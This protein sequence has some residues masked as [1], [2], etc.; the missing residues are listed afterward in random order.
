MP[1][2]THRY[3][4]RVALR[5][6]ADRSLFES[7]AAFAAGVPYAV[8]CVKQQL[9]CASPQADSTHSRPW[10][11]DRALWQQ[12][13]LEGD[14]QMLDAL[15]TL[16]ASAS[17]GDQLQR[18]LSDIVAWSLGHTTDVALLDWIYDSFRGMK[19]QQLIYYEHQL[20]IGVRGS[21]DV[22]QWMQR[23]G[24]AVQYL[25][26]TF[27]ATEHG[28]LELLRFVHASGHLTFPVTTIDLAATHGHLD[29]VQFLHAFPEQLCSSAA[30][31][32]AARN[33]HVAIV[34]FL[35]AHRTE[36]D[37]NSAMRLATEHGHVAC[38]RYLFESASADMSSVRVPREDLV[39]IAAARGH[40]ACLEYFHSR[41]DYFRFTE[42]AMHKAAVANHFAVV[43]FL[44]EHRTE[45]CRVDTLFDADARGL[46]HIVDYLCTHRPMANA[47]RAIARAKKEQHT[48]LA[49]KLEYS[50]SNAA[51]TYVYR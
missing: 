32:G 16:C 10:P 17:Y 39:N 27:A 1:R 25:P 21:V 35:H 34:R 46:H 19:H 22:V 6:L 33:G 5:V 31:N 12:A 14:M 7:I 4:N 13:V 8:I 15:Y 2:K 38:V 20:A 49:A 36:G 24:L 30:M 41:S 44:H 26:I 9:A 11:Q 18:V 51:K 37:V 45:G 40:L 23:R 48:L 3:T 42:R 43:R 28:H 50:A 29:I 47:A